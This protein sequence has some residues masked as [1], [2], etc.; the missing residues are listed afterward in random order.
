ME[1]T[2]NIKNRKI[3]VEN[4]N[5]TPIEIKSIESKIRKDM[6]ELEENDVVDTITQLSI[7][8][9]KYAVDS[10][11]KSVKLSKFENEV[12]NKLDEFLKLTQEALNK[13]TLF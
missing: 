1:K 12:E 10:Y 6:E 13:N 4:E 11:V 5:L 7:L 9:A 2:I 3:P 8:V